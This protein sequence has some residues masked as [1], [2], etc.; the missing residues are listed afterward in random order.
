MMQIQAPPLQRL[1]AA[2]FS[3]VGSHDDE[4]AAVAARLVGANLVGHD[5]HGVIRVP[6]Y[7]SWVRDGKVK[8][9]QQIEVLVDGDVMAILD[10]RQ[11]FGQVIGE[12]AMRLGIEKARDRGVAVI[13]LR[14][15]AHLGRIGDWAVMAAEAGLISL[16]FVNTNGSGILVAPTGGIQRRLSANP[17]A[18]GAPTPDGP[19]IILDISTCAIAEGKIRV[20]LTRGDQTPENSIIDA[21]GKPTTDPNV[22]YG[23]PPGAILPFGAHKGYGLGV[24]VEVLA[25]ALTGNGCSNPKN[26]GRL[27]QGM[28][29]VLLDPAAF[30]QDDVF[31]NEI[32]QFIKFVKSSKTTT[33]DGI[34]MM[35]GEIEE[36]TKAQRRQ[37]GIPL[38]E[39]TWEQ[40]MQV[41]R[42]L[43]IS[44][45]QVDAMMA[46]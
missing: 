16:H 21:E 10:G 4:A 28:L 15:S 7:V 12:Q 6:S 37:Q 1:V 25:G 44:Q 40:L 14:N 5:S 36:R 11:G 19:P 45:E 2:I 30:Q 3:A 23:T 26:A 32:R 34:I 42:S 31:Q 38:D 17:I 39:T 9:N 13:A 41:C 8:P 18:A 20:A 43:E 46:G 27:C 29:T 22:F 35:P 33:P 24:L